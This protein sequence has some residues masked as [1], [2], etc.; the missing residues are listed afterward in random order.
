MR[1]RRSPAWT[2]V[3]A[4]ALLL[5]ACGGTASDGDGGSASPPATPT[6]AP[7][8]DATT[9]ADRV[10]V[11]DGLVVGATLAADGTA[12]L[13]V[14]GPLPGGGTG[15]EGMPLGGLLAQTSG[16]TLE[17]VTDAAGRHITSGV[18]LAM[19]PGVPGPGARI[20]IWS[21]C[22]K[23]T[24]RVLV[25]VIGDDGVPTEL[26]E[27]AGVD[28]EGM[29]AGDPA[30]ETLHWASWS[31]DG[32][33]LLLIGSPYL[34]PEGGG[35]DTTTWEY[36][37]ATAMWTRRTDVSTEVVVAATFA[38]GTMLTVSDDV[39]AVG[40]TSIPGEGARGASIGPDGLSAA[41]YGP[42]GVR[43]VGS[44]GTVRTIATDDVAQLWWS[45]D[46]TV[47]AFP[48]IPQGGAGDVEL[49]IT[50]VDPV[51]GTT[52]VL[53]TTAW[54][55]IALLPDGSG[56]GV[57]VSSDADPYLPAAQRWSFA[58]R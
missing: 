22:E 48:S 41:V 46:G 42:S 13:L 55:W 39:I 47:I 35:V 50:T 6:P 2:T 49:A 32:T 21:M 36:D 54:G 23:V 17:P 16:G 43:I 9:I 27:V 20:A 18:W 33:S 26:V 14:D 15:C 38:D 51:G 29:D 28:G 5:A 7:V 4:A 25:G 44:D 53:G 12:T 24:S 56:L 45:A 57:T 3:A 40:G 30:F 37:V 58:R 52:T 11:G 19:Q 34:G 8:Y 31:P 1:R 10:A